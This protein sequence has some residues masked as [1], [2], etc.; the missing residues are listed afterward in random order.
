MNYSKKKVP[1]VYI[2]A[3]RQ[4]NGKTTTCVGLTSLLRSRFGNVGF[5][6]PVG[7]HYV[8]IDGKK[9]D[10][11]A[12]LLSADSGSND[13]IDDMN[14][15]VV[16]RKFTRNFIENPSSQIYEKRIQKCFDRIAENKDVVVIE[17]TGHAGVGS[18]FGYNNARVAKMLDSPAIIVAGGGIGKPFDEIIL[19]QALFEK[20]GVDIAGV[21]INKVR[22]EKLKEI[23]RYM[24]KAL[25][26]IGLNLLAVIPHE[27]YLLN[28]T[29]NHI[30]DN[31]ENTELINGEK[32][33]SNSVKEIIIGAMSPH[34]ALRFFVKGTL[35]VTP[36]D[37]DDLILTAISLASTSREK[38]EKVIAG[39]VLTGE[40]PIREEILKVIKRT[41]IPVVVSHDNAY[42]VASKLF[43]MLVKVRPDET[44]KIQLIHQLY[45]KYFDIEKLLDSL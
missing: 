21:V 19:N 20:N 15:I 27:Q 43:G 17:G 45:K 3:T 25:T 9:I 36:G 18:I 23:E 10:E 6:K 7:Q 22:P 34:Q 33:L 29:I 13:K 11:D 14:P 1:R 4:N 40:V 32:N 30:L 24:R 37:R 35:L 42:S 41:E 8:K 38:D 39:I 5:I 2:A 44:K 12:V 31:I 28:P 16:D 26:R